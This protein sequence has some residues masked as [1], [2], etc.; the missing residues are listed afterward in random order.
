MCIITNKCTKVCESV[1]HLCAFV[2]FDVMSNC[3]V[4]VCGS[5]IIEAF[6]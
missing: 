6:L 5:F 3:T 1:I 4:Q 2:G